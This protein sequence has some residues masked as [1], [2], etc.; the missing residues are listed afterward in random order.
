MKKLISIAALALMTTPASAEDF[1]NLAVMNLARTGLGDD[2][3]LAKIAS[4]PCSYDVS[5]D[6]LIALKSAGVSNAVIAAMVD[7]CVGSAAAQG[8]VSN[9][10]NPLAMRQAGLY[11][12]MGQ[13]GAHSLKRIRPTTASGGR[14][15]GNGSLLFPY[16]LQM[17]IPRDTAQTH[18]AGKTPT[19]YF[20]FETDDRNVGDFGTSA[21]AAAQSPTEFSLVRFKN[22][23]G[24]RELT[25]GKAS[26]FGAKVG[27]DPKLAIQFSV[28]EL[29]D[30]IF[31]VRPLT[32]LQPGE[33]GFVL[34]AG[35]DA[36]RIYDFSVS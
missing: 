23:D 32:A 11:I 34:S 35:S 33:Y 24:Q 26:A 27:I 15:T 1:N 4:L 25:V 16:K 3:I 22:K 28:E 8:A 29:Q 18:A 19:F 12:D 36:Y 21:T 30:G 13:A 10:S 20:Y 31:A 7:R 17:G 5:T 14:L 9:E 6:Q 2:V